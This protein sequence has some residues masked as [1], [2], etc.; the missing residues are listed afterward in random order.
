MASL[1]LDTAGASPFGAPLHL[2]YLP[3]EVAEALSARLVAQ[4]ARTRLQR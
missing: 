3:L 2:Q 4:L 1:L